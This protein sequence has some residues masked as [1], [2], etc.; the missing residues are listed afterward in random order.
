MKHKVT[1][2]V[3]GALGASAI[4]VALACSDS[5]TSEPLKRISNNTPGTGASGDSATTGGGSVGSPHD[6]S[7]TGNPA[8][9]PVPT[10]TLTLHVGTPH[11]G[12]ADTLLNDP[13]PG[14]TVTVAKFDYVFTSGAGAD[15]V[16]IIEVPVATGTTDSNGEVS[17]PNLKGEPNYV[18]KAAPPAGLNLG[19]ARV[20]LPQAYAATMRTTLIL[21]KP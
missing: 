9:K 2:R 18:V 21:R 7:G 3:L 20:V 17:F 10:F 14:A 16:N 13:L 19:S 5:S 15:T 12:A 4:V 1:R 11:V 6:S 8:P